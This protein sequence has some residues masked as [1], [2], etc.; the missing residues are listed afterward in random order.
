MYVL[1]IGVLHQVSSVT[2]SQLRTAFLNISWSP[3]SAYEG[4]IV[5]Y[6]ISFNGTYSTQSNTW[7]TFNTADRAQCD[8]ISLSITPFINA[9]DQ[10]LVGNA[11]QWNISEYDDNM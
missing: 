1:F 10:T 5:L 9:T 3:V 7:T 8:Y 11:S 6:N 4:L 2:V